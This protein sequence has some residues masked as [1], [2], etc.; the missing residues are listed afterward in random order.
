MQNEVGPLW[1]QLTLKSDTTLGRGDGVAGL[2]DAEVQHDG[3]GLPYLSGR[4]LKG[5]LTGECAEVLHALEGAAPSAAERWN[6]AARFLFGEPGSRLDSVGALHIGDAQ[7]PDDLREA[8]KQ[9]FDG[10]KDEERG[11]M[12]HANLEALTALRRQTALDAMGVPKKDT[13]RTMRVILRDTPFI[14]RL[15][16]LEPPTEDAKQLLAAT[17][18]ALRRIGTGRHR[19]R[20]RVATRLFDGAPWDAGSAEVTAQWLNEFAKEVHGASTHV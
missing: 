17:C 15:D 11:R 5:L 20:G 13:L 18:S 12:A 3:Y 6:D 7:L 9:T 4:T 10:R 19:G 16:W 1:L 2:V 8:V 14:A